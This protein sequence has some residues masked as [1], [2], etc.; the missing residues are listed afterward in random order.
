M[1]ITQYLSKIGHK[2][3]DSSYYNHIENWLEWYKGKVDEFH[4]YTIYNGNTMVSRERYSLGMAKRAPEDWANL[5]MN[6]KVNIVSSQIP[7][8]SEILAYSNFN[9]RANQLIELTYALGTGAFVEY[10]DANQMPIVDY[11]R[12]D[13]IYP[14]SWDNGDITECV[15]ASNRKA[16]GKECIYLQMHEIGEDGTYKITNVM[17]EEESGKEIELVGIEPIIY[18]GSSKPLFQIIT[19]NIANNIDLDCPMGISVYANAID[20]LKSIDMV[21]DSYVNEFDL[22]RKRLMIPVSM[23][24]MQMSNDGITKPVFDSKDSLFYGVEGIEKPYEINMSLRTQEHEQGMQRMLNLF[25]NKVGLGNDR[26]SFE[27]GAA[28]TAT[29]VISE[30]SDLYQNL[31]KNKITLKSALENMVIAIG[32]LMG[33]EITDVSVNLDDSIIEDAN[34]T[35]DKNIKLVSAELRSKTDAIMDIEKCTEAEAEAK[36]DKINAENATGSVDLT[37]IV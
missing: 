19:P 26:Y 23:A 33:K 27:K 1:N 12:A 5:L 21:Y 16:N 22:G 2:T 7:N 3:I 11:V 35:I 17:V 30:K 36:I 20:Q 29:E 6:E 4:K 18:T 8:L 25:S 10:L 24:K 37:G 31:N 34:A 28:K 13:M 32:F 15:F 14:L 9:V